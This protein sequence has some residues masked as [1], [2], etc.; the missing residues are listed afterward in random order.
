MSVR[1]YSVVVSISGCDPLDPGSNPGTANVL[2]PEKERVCCWYAGDRTRG[3]EKKVI[4]SVVSSLGRGHACIV[5]F[6]RMR[7]VLTHCG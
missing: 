3:E 4:R 1:S 5:P 6:Y 7:Q 2:L